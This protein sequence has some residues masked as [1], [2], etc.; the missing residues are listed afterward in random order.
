MNG[1]DG[2][3]RE[4]FITPLGVGRVEREEDEGRG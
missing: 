3:K 4:N 1:E 2:L